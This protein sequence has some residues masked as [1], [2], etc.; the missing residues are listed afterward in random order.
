MFSSL[1]LSHVMAG[2][3]GESV[4]VRKWKTVVVRVVA[5]VGCVLNGL[6]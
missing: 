6:L 5:A 3:G 1:F 2:V 4:I